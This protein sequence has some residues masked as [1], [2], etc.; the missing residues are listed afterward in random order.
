MT[1]SEKLDCLLSEVSG[2]KDEIYGVRREAGSI[3]EAI[4]KIILP[5]INRI[6]KKVN[7]LAEALLSPK[8]VHR[9]KNIG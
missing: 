1:D 7:L 4:S 9:L 2:L 6:D 8:E 5:T 3:K